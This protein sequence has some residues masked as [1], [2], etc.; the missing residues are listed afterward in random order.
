MK[1]AELIQAVAVATGKGQADAK[2][3]VE[4]VLEAI[5]QGVEKDGEARLLGFGS[6]KK[7]TRAARVG[8]NP[9]T[10][11]VLEIPEKQIVKFKPYF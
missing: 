5:K 10:G 6:F 9:S 1:K 2:I 11:G 3:A 8:R 4:T 7:I